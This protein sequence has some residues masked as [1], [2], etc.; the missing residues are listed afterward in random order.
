[1]PR[2]DGTFPLGRYF[3]WIYFDPKKA[4]YDT[5]MSKQVLQVKGEDYRLGNISLHGSAGLYDNI[6][7]LDSS[8]EYFDFK[9]MLKE[10]TNA[11]V[12]LLLI[13]MVWI[14]RK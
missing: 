10:A 7:R 9:K 13:A 14:F 4:K 12:I 1:V 11:I 3:Q 2:Q 6:E 8:Q 5:L